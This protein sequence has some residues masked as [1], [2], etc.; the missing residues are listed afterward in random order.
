ALAKAFGPPSRLD[1]VFEPEFLGDP[2]QS[3]VA[4]EEQFR[5]KY[6]FSRRPTTRRAGRTSSPPRTPGSSSTVRRSRRPG[7]RSEMDLSASAGSISRTQVTPVRI[8]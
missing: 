2:A 1:P 3:I 5:T 6:V 7:R 8:G 4:P